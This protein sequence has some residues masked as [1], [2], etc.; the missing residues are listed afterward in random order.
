ML[1]GLP[2]FLPHPFPT[3]AA[4]SLTLPVQGPPPASRRASRLA[5][6]TTATDDDDS[7][8]RIPT[9]ALAVRRGPHRLGWGRLP[10]P[11]CSPRCPGSGSE[12]ARP[13]HAGGFR[14]QQCVAYPGCCCRAPHRPGGNRG[15]RR[16]GH[17][18][19]GRGPPDRG[20]VSPR[21]TGTGR[22]GHRAAPGSAGPR[23]APG[24]DHPRP[25]GRCSPGIFPPARFR[26]GC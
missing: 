4:P 11:T 1:C 14:D 7:A 3:G 15:S 5:P 20:T 19:P 6:P 2:L 22:R 16:S 10:W 17:L 25:P 21:I 24:D 18:R 23:P 13:R 9:A 8:D 26:S 12:G